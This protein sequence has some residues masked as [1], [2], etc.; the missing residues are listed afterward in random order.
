MPSYPPETNTDESKVPSFTL[1]E[2]LVS[3]DGSE[4]ASTEAW[5]NHRRKE[6]LAAYENEIYG[7][8]PA[9]PEGVHGVVEADDREVFGGR[10][11]RK[12]VSLYL[13]KDQT[14]PVL[15]LLIYL[16]SRQERPAP[17][18]LGLNFFGNPTIYPDPDIALT[19]HWVRRRDDLG[20]V[21]NRL[22]EESRGS[23]SGRWP[24]EAILRRGYGLA[25]L[26]CGD[27]D[28]DN[29]RNDWSDGVHPLFYKE[30]QTQPE[31]HEW[32]AISAWAWGLSRALDYLVTDEEVDSQKV[33]VMGHSRLGKTALWAG[34]TDPRFSLVISNESGCG[35]ATLFRR[36]FG[37]M[38][39]HLTPIVPYWF[40]GN[41]LKYT[42]R[43]NDLPIDQHMLIA[44]AAPRPVYVSSA[45]EDLW[46]DPRGE[47]LAAQYAGEAYR[48][49]GLE[50]LGDRDMPPLGEPIMHSVGY[51]IRPGS[52]NV[53]LYDWERWMDFADLHWTT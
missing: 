14:G 49:Y 28:P 13:R 8:M 40:C 41:F 39:R 51:H 6:I 21:D 20:I 35:G 36:E 24:V 43:E 31:P 22:T 48:L 18:F 32:G 25:T 45:A 53:T 37:E 10:A 44:L 2:L 1:P 15:K 50:G 47:F 5:E 34:A 16:P 30:G 23:L 12:Q 33:A 46:C 38:I 19:D 42:D 7:R 27:L 11:I 3:E 52:H 26:Y 4:V 9:P 29:Y 17:L